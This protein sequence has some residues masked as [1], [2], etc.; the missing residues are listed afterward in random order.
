VTSINH[1][2]I[3]ITRISAYCRTRRQSRAATIAAERSAIRHH[4]TTPPQLPCI[5]DEYLSYLD[6][7]PVDQDPIPPPF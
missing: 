4:R 1:T 6:T 3:G 2:D 7:F 5:P